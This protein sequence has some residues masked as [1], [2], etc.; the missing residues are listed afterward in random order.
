MGRKALLTKAGIAIVVLIGTLA[1]AGSAS[2]AKTIYVNESGVSPDG[3][4]MASGWNTIQAGI[5]NA[6]TELDFGGE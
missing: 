6:S 3:M 2:A 5:N 1:F 4:N